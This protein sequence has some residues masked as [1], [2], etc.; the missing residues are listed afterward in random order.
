M[1]KLIIIL[2]LILVSCSSNNNI[3]NDVVKEDNNMIDNNV[4]KEENMVDNKLIL[5][6]DGKEIDVIWE[7]N[8]SIKDLKNKIEDELVIEMSIYSN[9]EQFGPLGFNL[10]SN[11]TRITSEIGDIF[12]YNS[13]NIVLFYGENTWSYT[14]LGKINMDDNEIIDLLSKK[15]VTITL[16]K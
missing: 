6:I 16:H 1:K 15:D 5:E 12:L 8:E 7:D 2:F 10:I 13:N 9:F 3:N 14:R 11:D 4:V